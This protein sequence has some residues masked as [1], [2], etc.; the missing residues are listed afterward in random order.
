MNE[1]ER[2]TRR[3]RIDPKLAAS[4]WAIEE[5][6]EAT[7][8]GLTVPTALTELPTHDGPTDYALCAD[9][10]VVGVVEAK[11]LTIGPQG[12][13]TQAERYS[14]GIQQQPRYQG[15]YGVPLL[16][17][18]NGEVIRFHDVRRELNRSRDVSAFHTPDALR[19]LLSRDFEAELAKLG[20]ITPSAALRPYQIEANQAIE[21]AIAV[22]QRS[23]RI[24]SPSSTASMAR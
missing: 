1:R 2:D 5:A 23:A 4:G 20:S 17:S 12:V 8:A 14:R 10:R 13:L 18:T 21:D 16:Y 15:E 22:G 24:I 9:A 19:E 11:K 6:T 3:R 7:P